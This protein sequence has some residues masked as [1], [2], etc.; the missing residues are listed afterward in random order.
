MPGTVYTPTLNFLPALYGRHYY[1]HVINDKGGVRG[2]RDDHY[3]SSR[4]D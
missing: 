1:P 4:S 2:V 3:Y